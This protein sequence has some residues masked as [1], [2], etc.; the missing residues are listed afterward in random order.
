M[1]ELYE[2]VHW[3][4]GSGAAR[5]KR[6]REVD[7]TLNADTA[8]K[9]V[10]EGTALLWLGD[11]HQARQMLQALSRRI[12]QARARHK[13]PAPAT[14]T[15]AFHQHR[16]AQ[17]ERARILGLLVLR[18]EIGHELQLR[19]APDARAAAEAAIGPAEAPYIASMRELLGWIGA[20]EWRQQG[21]EVPALGGARIH[22]HYGVFSPVRG[23]YLDLIA[24]APL[25]AAPQ[26]LFD[27]GTGSGVIAALLARR[28]PAARIEA[29][30][31]SP[32]ALACAADNLQRLGLRERVQL[33]QTDLFPDGRADLIVCNPPWLP[34]KPSSALEAAV[35]DPDSRM[36]RGFLQGLAAHLRP[37][38]EG[39]LIVSDLA[40]HLGLRSREQLL[41]WISAAG[42]QVLGLH[43]IRPRHPKAQDASDPLHQARKR[44]KTGLWRLG[45]A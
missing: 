27:I 36:L 10:C 26:T 8:Y 42:L 45:A 12:D 22:P 21:V 19:R 31:L 3:H 25:P 15:E 35:Y 2:G 6:W 18:F 32:Q 7:D 39:W 23:E 28:C 41:E 33:V 4:S 11:Y 16:K 5:P 24:Q 13:K 34:A 9:L 29:T 20:W 40:E 43:E 30:D 17:A 38:G 14:P 1:S 37:G 44:E